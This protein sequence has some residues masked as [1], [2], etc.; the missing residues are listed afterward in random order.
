MVWLTMGMYGYS[1]TDSKQA[2]L[3]D[4]PVTVPA[5]CLQLGDRDPSGDQVPNL[6]FY[7]DITS[8]RSLHFFLA[9]INFL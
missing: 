8:L 1:I 7:L 5:R 4:T 2:I 9:K 6:N 3:T